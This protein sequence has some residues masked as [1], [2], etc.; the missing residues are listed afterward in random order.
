[1]DRKIGLFYYEFMCQ[2][3]NNLSVYCLEMAMG[4]LEKAHLGVISASISYKIVRI[5]FPA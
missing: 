5:R 3:K 4:L 1:M 2:V